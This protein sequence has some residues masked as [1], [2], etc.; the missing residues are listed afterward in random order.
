MDDDCE[1]S[2]SKESAKLYVDQIKNNPDKC[3]LFSDTILK[4][5]AISKSLFNEVDFRDGSVENG[6]FFEDI[7][8]VNTIKKK[9]PNR[10]FIFK[11]GNLKQ[12][13]NNYNDENSTWYWGQYNKHDIGDRTRKIL[14]GL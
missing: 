2:G 8:F 4:L 12:K 13:S 9:F 7:L 3:G 11:R 10:V 14:G 6:D 1:L 5:F